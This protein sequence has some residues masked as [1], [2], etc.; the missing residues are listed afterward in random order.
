M[1]GTYVCFM[2]VF[3]PT[4]LFS[5]YIFYDFYTYIL[6]SIHIL[7]LLGRSLGRTA[8]TFTIAVESLFTLQLFLDQG[9]RERVLVLNKNRH[10]DEMR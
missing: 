4:A 5:M 7:Y 6:L 2:L 10:H 1:L 3:I 9:M 8:P